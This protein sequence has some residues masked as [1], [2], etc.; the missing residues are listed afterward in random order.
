MY[1]TLSTISD[2]KGGM[3]EIKLMDYLEV[4]SRKNAELSTKNLLKDF[5]SDH[6]FQEIEESR[7]C[8]TYFI[9]LSNSQKA[10]IMQNL[11]CYAYH[12]MAALIVQ[13]GRDGIDWIIP[14]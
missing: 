2:F 12:Q 8:F 13:E 3:Q 14:L 4:S 11:L 1:K 10:R 9:Y 6:L 5:I 7:V